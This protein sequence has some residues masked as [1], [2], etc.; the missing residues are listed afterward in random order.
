MDDVAPA[1]KLWR[2][3]SKNHTGICIRPGLI[4]AQD[5]ARLAINDR[6]ELL[7]WLHKQI[8]ENIRWTL[9]KKRLPGDT[10]TKCVRYNIRHLTGKNSGPRRENH[11]SVFQ[12]LQPPVTSRLTHDMPK[13]FQDHADQDSGE[14]SSGSVHPSPDLPKE[15]FPLENNTCENKLNSTSYYTTP[16]RNDISELD[17]GCPKWWMGSAVLMEAKCWN[18]EQS[19]QSSSFCSCAKRKAKIPQGADF[20]T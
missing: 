1:A 4:C 11:T 5:V 6:I 10:N 3:Q 19:E 9:K 18:P 15:S 2:C 20:Y 8:N 13:Y 14:C 7:C 17:T 16:Y 12:G